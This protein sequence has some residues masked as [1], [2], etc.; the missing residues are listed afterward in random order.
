M[1]TLTLKHQKYKEF[2]LGFFFLQ[3]IKIMLSNVML[4]SI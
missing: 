1:N 3:F 2:L 4:K